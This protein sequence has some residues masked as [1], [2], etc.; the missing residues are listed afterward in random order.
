MKKAEK[1][2]EIK[3]GPVTSTKTAG[4]AQN[5]QLKTDYPLSEKD[6]VKQAEA[7]MQRRR[8]AIL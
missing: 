3:E 2:H 6:E 4:Q 1:E 7:N 8:R 5:G